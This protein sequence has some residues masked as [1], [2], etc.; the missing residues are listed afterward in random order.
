MES[1]DNKE[2]YI[3][4]IWKD[5]LILIVDNYKLNYDILKLSLRKFNLNTIWAS[6]GLEA[7]EICSITNNIN[8]I[9]MDIRMPVMDGYEAAAKIKNLKTNAPAIIAL[10]AY[11]AIENKGKCLA[12]G[13]DDYLSKPFNADELNEVLLKY[14]K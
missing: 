2:N 9:F 12:A 10:T 6:N 13:F 7:V 14:L 8:L 3:P 5:K 11:S 1:L 4:D